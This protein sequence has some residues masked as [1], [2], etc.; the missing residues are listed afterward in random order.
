MIINAFTEIQ[1]CFD[2]FDYEGDDTI[3]IDDIG[4]VMRMLGQTP[5]E[6][7]L[8]ELMKESGAPGNKKH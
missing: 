2:E 3:E 1:K 6:Q 8:K 4:N 7:E 5:T